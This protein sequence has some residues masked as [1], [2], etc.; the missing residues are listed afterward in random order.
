MR[1]ARESQKAK[2][3]KESQ[4]LQTPK[5]I[6]GD[7]KNEY[8]GT[9]K[10]LQ[11]KRDEIIQHETSKFADNVDILE[12]RY[13]TVKPGAALYLEDLEQLAKRLDKLN[14]RFKQNF[15]AVSKILNRSEA[16]VTQWNSYIAAKNKQYDID[17]APETWVKDHGGYAR[18]G[19]GEVFTEQLD[20]DAYDAYV[21]EKLVKLPDE[22]DDYTEQM[23]ALLDSIIAKYK[24]CITFYNKILALKSP[25]DLAQYPLVEKF[26]LDSLLK[27]LQGLFSNNI[28]RKLTSLNVKDFYQVAAA[29]FQKQTDSLPKLP[30][31]ITALASYIDME[32]ESL[33]QVKEI[34]RTLMPRNMQLARSVSVIPVD[35][36][37]LLNIKMKALSSAYEIK[38]SAIEKTLEQIENFLVAQPPD[39]KNI[40][41]LHKLKNIIEK[42]IENYKYILSICSQFRRLASLKIAVE[43]NPAQKTLLAPVSPDHLRKLGDDL[44]ELTKKM[45]AYDEVIYDE[46]IKELASFISNLI[47]NFANPALWP[48]SN[49]FI[50]K[51]VISKSL[52]M[53]SGEYIETTATKVYPR[54]EMVSFSKTQQEVNQT[55][56]TLTA[57]LTMLGSVAKSRRDAAKAL[58]KESLSELYE[59]HLSNASLRSTATF[60]SHY[61]ERNTRLGFELQGGFSDTTMPPAEFPAEPSEILQVLLNMGEIVLDE[62]D[63]TTPLAESNALS[64][65]AP[66]EPGLNRRITLIARHKPQTREA[67]GPP[68]PRVFNVAELDAQL[69]EQEIQ[70]TSASVSMPSQGDTLRRKPTPPPKDVQGRLRS[71]SMSVPSSEKAA[72]VKSEQPYIATDSVVARVALMEEMKGIRMKSGSLILTKKPEPPPKGASSTHTPSS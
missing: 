7:L 8:E 64:L 47:K 69:R 1:S 11:K 46:V 68:K 67:S 53:T 29:H 60:Y 59:A 17:N 9:V 49:L 65:T 54:S 40:N 24:E 30:I 62:K 33:E 14:Q 27:Q 38:T 26:G 21:D 16:L 6:A 56:A 36:S 63:P 44:E 25:E 45:E 31:T 42:I 13:G 2:E 51:V 70:G 41:F 15:K 48:S 71:R 39:Q 23:L 3:L 19:D 35:K 5:R 43:T 58:P 61:S 55:L 22:L 28:I 50:I 18:P 10:K 12:K 34:S 37:A 57:K 52:E 32:Q 66:T 72:D 20:M 4:K